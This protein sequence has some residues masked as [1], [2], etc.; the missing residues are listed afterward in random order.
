MTLVRREKRGALV[1]RQAGDEEVHRGQR[2]PL[3]AQARVHTGIRIR[4]PL[5]WQDDGE[6]SEDVQDA[7]ALLEGFV[8][9]LGAD[10]DLSPN[11]D[12]HRQRLTAMARKP[13]PCRSIL[14]APR[15]PDGV[16]KE[17]RVEVNHQEGSRTGL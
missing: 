10:N 5:I 6:V 2:S 14:S 7:T 17:G 12:A 1:Q 16:D 11:E 15:L 9:E 3:P 4:K 8:V 13:L